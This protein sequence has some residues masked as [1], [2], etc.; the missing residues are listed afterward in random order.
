MRRTML[1]VL[2]G[3]LAAPVVA[4]EELKIAGVRTKGLF[5]SAAPA[6]GQFGA[7]EAIKVDVTFR[8]VSKKAFKLFNAAYW[9]Y[10]VNARGGSW[11]CVLKNTKTGKA[12]RPT[13]VVRPMIER[14]AA[15]VTLAPGKSYKTTVQLT[16]ALSYVPLGKVEKPGARP[17]LA[18]TPLPAG[19]YQLDLT[20][21][22]RKGRGFVPDKSPAP[23]WT[24][25]VKLTAAPFDFGGKGAVTA[26]VKPGVWH[27][28]SGDA[29]WYKRQKSKEREFTGTLKVKP[30]PQP[31]MIMGTSLM[32][33]CYYWLGEWRIYTGARRV[34]VLEQLGGKKV[35][36][37][38]KAVEMNLEGQHLKE[39]WPAT[40]KV[41]E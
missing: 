17:R 1:V 28:L 31:G 10:E 7:G 22:F 27:K 37:R 6:K 33:P 35:V 39:I 15:P 14:I 16:R 38:G 34:D 13:V 29:R 40:V 18:M 12:Y 20:L 2:C 32:R 4:G 30:K 25:T 5:V 26:A 36:I 24:G 21:T 23:F 3:L 11:A 41:T 19:R 9:V 8:N